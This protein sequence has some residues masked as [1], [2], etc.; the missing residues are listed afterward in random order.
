MQ[1][2]QQQQLL[3]QLAAQAMMPCRI[4]NSNSSSSSIKVGR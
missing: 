1:S 2:F 3:Q 4:D